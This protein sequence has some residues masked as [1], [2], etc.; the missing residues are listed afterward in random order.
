MSPDWMCDMPIS[1][2]SSEYIHI[3]CFVHEGE[4]NGSPERALRAS[5]FRAMR[6]CQSFFRGARMF[7]VESLSEQCGR[8]EHSF[9]RTVTSNYWVPGAH[10]SSCIVIPVILT[11]FSGRAVSGLES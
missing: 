4:E 1:T 10:L 2:D 5:K 11:L 8:R 9:I 7:S 3:S 6:A